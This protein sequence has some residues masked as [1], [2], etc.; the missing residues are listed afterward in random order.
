[1]T[2]LD[3]GVYL[4][5]G[6]NGGSFSDGLGTVAP[7]MIPNRLK[8]AFMGNPGYGG[9][10]LEA[11]L[12]HDADVVAV[13]HQ[14]QSRAHYLKKMYRRYF[15]SCKRVRDG[16][17]RLADKWNVLLDE[18]S[19]V[20]TFGK[21]TVEVARSHQ[22]RLFDGSFVHDA[23]CVE[24]LKSLEVDVLLVA[25]F[26]EIL[27]PS[28][29]AAP[30]IVAMNMHPSL[31]PKYRGGF[32]EFNAVYNGEEKSG[33]SFHLMEEKFDTGNILLQKELYLNRGETTLSLKARLAELAS[34]AVPDLLGLI[35]ARDLA[36]SPQDPSKA[37]Y[38]ELKKNFDLIDHTMTTQHIMNVID[39]CYDVEDIARPHF[40]HKGVK[41]FA[42][43]YGQKGFPF[44][45]S[46]AVVAF[47][48]VR[49]GHKIYRGE[50]S[51]KLHNVL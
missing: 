27:P 19:P 8:I 25:T 34:N 42:L 43:S 51:F 30:T 36:G 11:L 29:L 12:K 4:L 32:P 44:K 37:T 38:C 9:L 26:G 1:V 31:L 49:Y 40:Y 23:R 39:A 6:K 5:E 28:L 16:F 15:R 47:D 3:H 21:D 33:I 14:S 48:S 20:P 46:D 24:V 18:K 7:L 22:I 13:F 2:A 50:P 35:E 41:I 10:V 45:A 17:H